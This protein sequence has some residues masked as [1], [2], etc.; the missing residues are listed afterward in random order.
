MAQFYGE[1]GMWHVNVWSW[2]KDKVSNHSNFQG[3]LTPPDI[4]ISGST[5]EIAWDLSR[6]G[7]RATGVPDKNQAFQSYE[8]SS[9]EQTS[10]VTSTDKL[11]RMG[12]GEKKGRFVF[13]YFKIT[14]YNPKVCRQQFNP[15]ES[16]HWK[17]CWIA[18]LKSH[19]MSN[20]LTKPACVPPTW[21][22]SDGNDPLGKKGGLRRTLFF[23]RCLID[24]FPHIALKTVVCLWC[25]TIIWL[26]W[27]RT[28][29]WKELS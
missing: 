28:L 16:G 26:L 17:L 2:L 3:W 25:R 22:C 12:A 10:S 13:F 15:G 21:A 7:R 5:G 20:G 18:D 27:A 29:V 23:Y 4:E 1:V 8:Q 6:G 19:Y 9:A 24:P 11:Q 14:F